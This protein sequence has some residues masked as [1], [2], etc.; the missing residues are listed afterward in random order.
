MRISWQVLIA[1]LGLVAARAE[2]PVPPLPRAH[3]HNDYE[4]TRPLLDALAQGFCSVEADIF[5]VNGQLLVAHDAPKVKPERTLQTL[6]LDPLRER[7]KG[8]GGR[9]YPDA[10]EFFLLI[11]I[12]TD[13]VKTYEVLRSVLEQYADLLT[14]FGP[15]ATVTNAVTV[16]LSGNCPRELLGG[17]RQRLAAIDGRLPDL[18]GAA[19]PRLI[20]WISENWRQ[21]FRWVEGE[22]M[23]AED[24]QKLRDLVA[25][26]HEQGRR[27]RFWGGPDGVALWRE[28][29]Q[30]GVDLINTD[31][32]EELRAFLLAVQ[33]H[34]LASP[35]PK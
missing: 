12:K 7:A 32:L 14:T 29:Y 30:A 6:Y 31:K 25:R 17:E 20:P 35:A 23:P 33:P 13:A 2:T 9:V 4:H 26:A 24:R 11:D 28:Q 8:H 5:L 16:V 15:D 3:A 1:G 34:S 27:V 18:D 10:P 22:G 21:R 19:S